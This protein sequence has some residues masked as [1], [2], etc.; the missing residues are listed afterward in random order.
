MRVLLFFA[1]LLSIVALVEPA[2]GQERRQRWD[3]A[4]FLQRLDRNGNA[5]LEPDEMVGRAK[6]FIE[7]L[8]VD[9]S[10][11]VPIENVMQAIDRQ[12]QEAD[13]ERAR[14]ES[15]N[16]SS[17]EWSSP[18]LVPGFGEEMKSTT[19]P[20]FG[21]ANSASSSAT[22]SKDQEEASDSVKS[23]V[24][25]VLGQYDQNKD[26]VLDANEI[27]TTPWGQPSPQ[28]SDVNGDGKL[29]REELIV[30]YRKRE[31]D[32]ERLNGN[33][34]RGPRS[35]ETRSERG[36]DRESD[37]GSDRGSERTSSAPSAA[38]PSERTTSPKS[39]SPQDRIANYVQDLLKQYDSNNDGSL[40]SDEQSKM[41]SVPKGADA[42]S[43]ELLS[44][45]ELMTYYGGGY[46]QPSTA[47]AEPSKPDASSSGE[48]TSG[49]STSR[50]ARRRESRREREPT[51]ASAN[52]DGQKPIKM[53]EFT[54]SWTEDK[55]EEFRQL[56][57]NHDGVISIEE[58]RQ[59]K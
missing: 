22:S 13:Q 23:Q 56:D 45:D 2:F 59:R 36:S 21:E 9:A 20:G 3:P 54:E 17:S 10:G 47:S 24:D 31:V 4:S 16:S 32:S 12:R 27:R 52:F 15:T 28:E 26:L 51:R 44:R 11:S 8:G 18:R 25:R 33:N 34:D 40:S 7:N 5:V 49:E 30:R 1:V 37:R 58:Y 38:S 19:L 43:N 14:S 53:H 29:T 41:K 6:G 57:A 39:S 48:S 42:D 35:S 50:E 46:K 55:L